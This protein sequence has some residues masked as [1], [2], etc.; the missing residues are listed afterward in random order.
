MEDVNGALSSRFSSK[1]GR[2]PPICSEQS[3]EERENEFVSVLAS[4][5]ERR[6][7]IRARTFLGESFPG[8]RRS[9]RA[10][11]ERENDDRQEET[12]TIIKKRSRLQSRT[13]PRR[14]LEA[15]SRTKK[16]KKTLSWSRIRQRFFQEKS[17]K[18]RCRSRARRRSFAPGT[19]CS[20]RG[21]E[22]CA[23]FAP[24]YCAR[25]CGMRLACARSPE[26]ERAAQTFL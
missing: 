19:L 6:R 9:A 4:E 11:R 15:F 8:R 12:T 21:G 22:K 7:R 13:L 18:R 2:Y 5:R 26:T 14:L 25:V 17:T 10:E 24:F 1:S 23:R 16:K 20:G 3:N